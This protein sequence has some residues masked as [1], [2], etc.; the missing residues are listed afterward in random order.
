M[1]CEIK[2][3]H[4]S[5]KNTAGNKY[6]ETQKI[7][8]DFNSDDCTAFVLNIQEHYEEGRN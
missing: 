6:V 4:T 1:W 7:I 3:K 2:I 8:L 5:K